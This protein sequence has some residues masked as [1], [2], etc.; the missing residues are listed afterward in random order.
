MADNEWEENRD[1]IETLFLDMGMTLSNVIKYMERKGFARSKGQYERQFRKWNLRKNRALPG[2]IDYKSIM[3]TV[4]RRKRLQGKDSEAVIFGRKFNPRM[5]QRLGYGK[6]YLR[7]LDRVSKRDAPSRRLPQGVIIRTP[8]PPPGSRPPFDPLCDFMRLTWS[9]SLPWRGRTI[10]GFDLTVLKESTFLSPAP[11]PPWSHLVSGCSESMQVDLLRWFEVVLP[12]RSGPDIDIASQISATLSVLMAEEHQGTHRSL[13]TS[14]LDVDLYLLSNGLGFDDTFNRFDSTI[15]S[16]DKRILSMFRSLGLANMRQIIKLLKLHQATVE[17]IAEKLFASAVRLVDVHV[18][19]MMLEANINPNMFIKTDWLLVTPLAWA[20]H[21]AEDRG[22]EL[23]EL[24][25]SHGADVNMLYGDMHPLLPAIRNQNTALIRLFLRCGAIAPLT[26]VAE[27]AALLGREIF[28]DLVIS[29]TDVIGLYPES[30][31][32]RSPLL[33]ESFVSDKSARGYTTLLGAAAKAGRREII[34]LL[35]QR[36][37]TLSKPRLFKFVTLYHSPLEFAVAMGHNE[38]ITPLILGGV[39]I[40]LTDVS[41]PTLLERAV[42]TGNME[43]FKILIEHGAEVDRPVNGGKPH[44]SALFEAVQMF[45]YSSSAHAGIV[46]ILIQRHARLNEEYEKTPGTVLAAAIEKGDCSIIAM[47]VEAGATT[48]GK[49][50]RRIGSIHAVQYLEDTGMLQGMLDICGNLILSNAMTDGKLDLAHWLAERL[51][52]Y[53]P[54]HSAIASNALLD[55]ASWTSDLRLV[56]S[57]IRLGATVTDQQ[58]TE[59]AAY[60][61]RTNGDNA[62]LLRLLREFRGNAPSFVAYAAFVGRANLIPI[63]RVHGALAAGI[64]KPPAYGWERHDFE[65]FD[66]ISATVHEPL[67]CLELAVDGASELCLSYILRMWTWNSANVG[68]ALALAILR[69]EQRMVDELFQYNPDVNQPVWISSHVRIWD[70]IFNLAAIIPGPECFT[71]LQAAVLDQDVQ[72]VRRLLNEYGIDVNYPALGSRGRTALQQAVETGHL[73]IVQ[74]LLRHGA[75]VNA[76][77]AP[78]GG[79]TALQLAAIKGYIGLVRKLIDLG[80]NVNAPGAKEE[81]R[82]ALQGAAEHGR[83]DI[84]QLLMEEGAT[85][86]DDEGYHNFPLPDFRAERQGHCA[87]ARLIRSFYPDYYELLERLK[88]GSYSSISDDESESPD[89]TDIEEMEDSEMREDWEVWIDWNP[90]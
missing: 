50:L 44:T 23:A 51:D 80:A 73:E 45:H 20:A 41:Q 89:Q 14:R 59:A 48:V 19:K 53:T 27:G 55:A 74:L 40:H 16:Q 49:G 7:T 31:N 54:S 33:N 11:A 47:L 86:H 30:F 13:A 52:T 78:Y 8:S 82:T 9:S 37:P 42:G 69:G 26:C 79:A 58:L 56:E 12:W 60:I 84:L 28:T 18:V 17:A 57:M 87:A 15:E 63:A 21:L 32:K 83:I 3:E 75:D 36:Y 25:I 81:G 77:P 71:P 5:L 85:L 39:D 76:V 4:E 64:P 67:S 29:C 24:L 70:N 34:E 10:M 65:N 72:L 88:N 90:L 68:R 43:A 35:L 38:C 61:E 66:K 46:S 22:L 2:E 1:E 62:V 6:G